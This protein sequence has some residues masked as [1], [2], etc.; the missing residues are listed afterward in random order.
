MLQRN[1]TRKKI[2]ESLHTTTNKSFHV[3]FSYS[4]NFFIQRRNKENTDAISGESHADSVHTL[5]KKLV[6]N[7]KRKKHK[8]SKCPTRK[9]TPQRLTGRDTTTT[10]SFRLW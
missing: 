2:L 1:K 4:H 5:T 9:P 3:F 8:A 6:Q 10:M 7:D